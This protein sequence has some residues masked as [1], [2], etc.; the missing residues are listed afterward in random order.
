MQPDLFLFSA[1]MIM[2]AVILPELLTAFR[3]KEVIVQGGRGGELRPLP[4]VNGGS[5]VI[6]ISVMIMRRLRS[7]LYRTGSVR[8]LSGLVAKVK[9]ARFP[10]FWGFR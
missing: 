3:D 6:Y 4:I 9:T 1:L 7:D 8:L 5:C 2:G 10:N